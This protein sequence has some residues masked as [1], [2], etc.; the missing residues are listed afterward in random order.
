MLTPGF[1]IRLFL[2]QLKKLCSPFHNGTRQIN[3]SFYY[4]TY[5]DYQTRLLGCVFSYQCLWFSGKK[6]LLLFEHSRFSNFLLSILKTDDDQIFTTK[7]MIPI[8]HC[9]LSIYVYQYDCSTCIQSIHFY[10]RVC[11]SFQNFVDCVAANIAATGSRIP[12]GNLMSTFRKGYYGR[13]G[14]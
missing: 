2:S 3:Q 4:P 10:Y 14:R 12:S 13:H 7:D 6:L 8:F 9:L 11:G 1:C 5:L